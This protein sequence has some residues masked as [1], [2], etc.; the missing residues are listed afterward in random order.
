MQDAKTPAIKLIDMERDKPTQGLTSQLVSALKL[1]LEQGEQSLLF[2]NRRGYAPVIAC[3]ACGWVSNCT[4]CTL[5][6]ATQIR[7]PLALPPLQPGL[8]VPR[9]CPTFRGNVDLQ[10][11]GRGTQE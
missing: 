4:R 9:A 5:H 3:D 11:L 6:G 1:R 7:A 8:R 10:A 2:L